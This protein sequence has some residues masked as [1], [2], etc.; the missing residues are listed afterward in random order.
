MRLFLII[1]TILFTGLSYGQ[2]KE[3][4]NR[5]PSYFGI[6]VR[7]IFPTRFIADPTVEIK[8]DGFETIFQQ[9]AGYSFGGTVRGGLTKTIAIETGINFTQRYFDFSASQVDSNF[10]I[11]DRIR[12]IEYDI[13]LNALFYIKLSEKIYA[14]TS[15]GGTILFRPTDVV[16]ENRIDAKNLFTHF[17]LADRIGFD[18]N[19]NVGFEYRTEKKGFFYIGGSIRVPTAELFTLISIYRHQGFEQR[20][21]TNISGAFMGIDFKYFFPNIRN[22]GPQFQ[23]GPIE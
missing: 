13:P 11:S 1:I 19:A 18:L 2:Q 21:Y 14:N 23:R 9:K 5:V 6:Q 7:P 15:L 8:E 22:K 12:F 10:H 4:R 20:I 16:R 17:G 3:K